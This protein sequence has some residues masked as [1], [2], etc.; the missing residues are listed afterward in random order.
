MFFLFRLVKIPSFVI[1][2]LFYII[3]LLYLFSTI[4]VQFKSF[5]YDVSLKQP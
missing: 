4:E 5:F 1:I 2:I 3:L